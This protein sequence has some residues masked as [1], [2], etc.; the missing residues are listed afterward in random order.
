MINV[1]VQ[2]SKKVDELW[3][4]IDPYLDE[5][6]HLKTNAPDSIREKHKEVMELMNKEYE[7]AL[8]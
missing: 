4:D 6:A 7:E 5:W 3:K 8:V 1:R 2:F